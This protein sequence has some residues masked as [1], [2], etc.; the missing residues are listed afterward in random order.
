MVWQVM[1]PLLV[2]GLLAL[3]AAVSTVLPPHRV[4]GACMPGRVQIEPPYDEPEASM[5][6]LP[7]P[8]VL[9]VT[10]VKPRSQIGCQCGE[11]CIESVQIEFRLKTTQRWVRIT[12]NARVLYVERAEGT[13]DDDAR[14]YVGP[15]R[16]AG[17]A[18]SGFFLAALDEE[19]NRS[20][21]V[22]AALDPN[23]DVELR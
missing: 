8:E 17:G 14:F 13:P 15:G 9:A 22:P 6:S 16:F 23:A 20:V 18:P 11:P 4:V 2:L 12:S 7:P 1:R 3:V 21:D 19:G 5:D 10:T